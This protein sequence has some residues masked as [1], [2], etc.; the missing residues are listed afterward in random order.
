V[1]TRPRRSDSQ[2]VAAVRD[3]D[4]AAYLELHR[5]Y[6]RQVKAFVRSVVK[7]RVRAEEITQE[8]FFQALTRIRDTDAEISFRDLAYGIARNKAGPAFRRRLV[9]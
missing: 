7:D 2:L 8:A 1:T 3:G 5:R 4:Y 9:D 6:H